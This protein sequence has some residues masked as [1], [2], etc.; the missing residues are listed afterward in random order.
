MSLVREFLNKFLYY[1]NLYQNALTIENVRLRQ[2]VCSWI[3]KKFYSEVKSMFVDDVHFKVFKFFKP[4]RNAKGVIPIG[5]EYIILHLDYETCYVSRYGKKI[6]MSFIG[7]LLIGLDD[8]FEKLFCNLLDR[9]SDV[10]SN[11]MWIDNDYEKSLIV[12]RALGYDVDLSRLGNVKLSQLVGKTVRVQ[13]D[14][15]I[16]IHKVFNNFNELV[17]YIFEQSLPA[18]SSE[19]AL[20]VVYYFDDI[21]ES[22]LN[23][24]ELLKFKT[25]IEFIDNSNIRERKV[26]V[27]Y[28]GISTNYKSIMMFLDLDLVDVFSDGKTSDFWL[29][30][31]YEAIIEQVKRVVKK[32]VEKK[33]ELLVRFSDSVVVKFPSAGRLVVVFTNAFNNL[34]KYVVKHVNVKVVKEK[35]ANYLREVKSILHVD[36]H[37]VYAITLNVRSDVSS[38]KICELLDS[39]VDEYV[40]DVLS[41]RRLWLPIRHE[42]EHILVP[43]QIV[44]IEH[45]EHGELDIF[46]DKYM[47]V[48][49]DLLRRDRYEETL[50]SRFRQNREL[51][52]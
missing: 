37:V 4:L 10:Y 38:E 52:L 16:T 39:S 44:T 3:A 12:K 6:R 8:D 23:K 43:N 25:L 31:H 35:I 5:D 40:L 51:S 13:G 32:F 15:T 26:V 22:R 9:R 50:R 33:L 46:I 45:P 34:A 18:L 14:L 17:N 24:Q 19:I 49:F 1:H 28:A 2:S 20:R 48:T 47:V 36:D 7:D 29:P 30:K 11:L 42:G 21:V 27:R 41:T